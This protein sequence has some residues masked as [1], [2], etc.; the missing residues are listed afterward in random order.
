MPALGLRSALRRDGLVAPSWYFHDLA[1]WHRIG[2]LYDPKLLTEVRGVL[3]DSAE[4]EK[5]K[6]LLAVL[7]QRKGH[8]VLSRVEAAKIE[9]SR[10]D[11]TTLDL[12]ACGGSLNLGIT[13]AQLEAAAA[14][15]LHRIRSSMT[16]VLRNAG[17]TPD[18]VSAVFLT[19]GAT[20]MPAVQQT[21]AAAIPNAR[22]VAGDVFGSVAKGL[23]LDAAKQ[24]ADW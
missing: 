3:R 7:E 13:R 23:A 11:H 18:A 12:A 14:D 4:P 9:L 22:L 24:F 16:D 10:A 6:R 21:I 1:T 5:I 2:F 17:V 20:R 8:E 19:G 15:N